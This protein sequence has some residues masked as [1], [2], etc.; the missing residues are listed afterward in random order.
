M[1]VI[2]LCMFFSINYFFFR[3]CV[4][5]LSANR[6]ENRAQ[7]PVQSEDFINE[8]ILTMQTGASFEVSARQLSQKSDD[9]A[10][11]FLLAEAETASECGEMT[12]I[13]AFCLKNASQSY[14]ILQTLRHVLRLRSRLSRKQEAISLQARAQ[15]VICSCLFAILVLVQW[16]INPEFTKFLATAMGRGTFVTSSVLVIAG[17]FLVL[18]LA[19][20][21]ELEF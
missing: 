16:K 8:L 10:R 13:L 21:R 14:K 20:P 18:R 2:K 3:T 5:I 7:P 17:L 19:K 1:S 9:F 6:G 11:I 12:R 4:R 15:A